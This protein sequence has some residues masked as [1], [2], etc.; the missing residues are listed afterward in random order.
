MGPLSGIEC[1]CCNEQ[2][3]KWRIRKRKEEKMYTT[4]YKL[5]TIFLMIRIIS[6]YN[7]VLLSSSNPIQS[8]HLHIKDN[9]EL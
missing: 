1:H 5:S 4:T 2:G 8:S 3:K 9:N 7:F 6:L